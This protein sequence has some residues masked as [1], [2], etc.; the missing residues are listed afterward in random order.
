[1]PVPSASGQSGTP[2]VAAP[3]AVSFRAGD[4][5]HLRHAVADWAGRAGLPG[6]RAADFVIAVHEIATN[7]IRHGSPV[8]RLALQIAG[9]AAQA[10]VRD[11]GHW[12]PQSPA[13]TAPAGLG[14]GLHVAH[15]VCDQVTI[16]RG[17]TGSTVTLQMNLPDS[18]PP[19]PG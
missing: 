2:P 10:E 8:A 9:T 14:M 5:R 7:A 15:R 3:Y 11:S 4:L 18:P 1:M 19:G 17:A 6:Q 16:H 13:A 12:P